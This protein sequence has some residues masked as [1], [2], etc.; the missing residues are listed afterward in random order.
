M[1][2][3]D[4]LRAGLPTGAAL[5]IS[6][7][8][9]PAIAQT[10]NPQL[11]N[12]RDHGAKGDGRADD[13]AALQ[14]AFDAVTD[15]GTLYIPT[16]RYRLTRT[17]SLPPRNG[18]RIFGDGPGSYVIADASMQ[19]LIRLD[20]PFSGGLIEQLT[21]D[22]AGKAET[23][24][25]V[26]GGIWSRMNC[27]DIFNPRDKG[28][29]C[30]DPDEPRSSG[31]ECLITN[32]R[33]TGMAQRTR[34]E[35]RSQMGILVEKWT[36]NHFNN[37]IVRG[38]NTGMEVRSAS[39]LFHQV[40]I[41]RHPAYQFDYGLR[42]RTDSTY[43]TQAYFDNPLRTY[44]DVLGKNTMFQG[45]FF[46][47]IRGAFGTNTDGDRVHATGIQLGDEKTTAHNV[48]VF[49]NSFVCR[50]PEG[51][52][53]DE[54]GMTAIRNVNS[55]NIISKDNQYF[56]VI[57]GETVGKGNL[58][59]PAGHDRV[60]VRHALLRQPSTVHLTPLDFLTGAEYKVD[61]VTGDVF[62]V[63]LSKP[64]ANDIRFYWKA[65]C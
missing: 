8:P 5:A 13:T 33:L 9:T 59:V 38:F 22:A 60:S 11:I 41:Y 42:I 43:L 52:T 51:F 57:G 28:L 44:V 36:D 19:D 10:N 6:A 47:R 48:T 24:L 12:V 62:L 17:V 18:V 14:K 30:G 65:E 50:L 1:D 20:R 49:A 61:Q 55:S 31:V 39:N 32:S 56:D 26:M 34:Q 25:R 37:L 64:A 40:H 53:H 29:H 58:T 3:R 54:A 23:A 2:R 27:L 21:I 46:L 45:C 7:R 4:F 15:N 63:R 16:G 35:H